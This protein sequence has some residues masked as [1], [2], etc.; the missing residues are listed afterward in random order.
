V[1]TEQT[2]SSGHTERTTEK[3]PKPVRESR[4]T[5]TTDTNDCAEVTWPRGPLA[6]GGL[7]LLFVAPL[8][9]RLLPPGSRFGLG[10]FL[11]EAGDSSPMNSLEDVSNDEAEDMKRV[12]EDRRAA[13]G[14]G[15]SA[16]TDDSPDPDAGSGGTDAG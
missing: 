14:A 7:G 6:L 1:D 15:A 9:L 3:Y 16:V 8:M 5:V 13:G 10:G 12:T 4:V 11:L 2:C